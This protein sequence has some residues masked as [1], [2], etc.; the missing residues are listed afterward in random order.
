M[1]AIDLLCQTQQIAGPSLVR[2][3]DTMHTQPRG[4]GGGG[5][6]EEPSSS[7]SPALRVAVP[8]LLVVRLCD[9]ATGTDFIR[10]VGPEPLGLLQLHFDVDHLPRGKTEHRK[11]V[12]LVLF[13]IPQA[14]Q[15]E[16]VAAVSKGLRDWN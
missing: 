13:A 11:C 7:S 3:S 10:Q 9:V 12:S 4:G 2:L 15:A 8:A 6:V 16:W 14:N 5:Q 1:G